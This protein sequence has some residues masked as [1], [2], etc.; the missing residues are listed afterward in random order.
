[1]A[2]CLRMAEF[3]GGGL[4]MGEEMVSRKTTK[5][6]LGESIHELA[7]VK[8]VDK[9]TVR[10]ITENG[11]FSPATFYRHFQ[12]KYDLIAW[13]Y[14]NQM[15]KIFMGFC[16]GDKSWRQAIFDMVDILEKDRGF[17]HNALKHTE[18]P[19][20]FFMS[21]HSRC[22]EL[23]TE[24]I[25]HF[26]KESVDEEML[27][28]ARFY[29]RG[30]SYSIIDWFL[31]DRSYSSDEIADYLFRAMPERLKKVLGGSRED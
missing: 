16:E 19:N 20:S 22:M 18:G 3:F 27:F 8:P 17:Y 1:M 9:I 24:A 28:D 12:D 2:L 26:G 30:I 21:T 10:E 29:L 25:L 11:G 31:N 23:L 14:N 5:E 4:E 13:D 6:I 7:K 15:E